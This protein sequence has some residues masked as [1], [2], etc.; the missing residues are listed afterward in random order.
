MSGEGFL[1]DTNVLSEFNH[2]QPP[3]PNVKQWVASTPTSSL[4][5][6]VIT[7]SEI[8][9]GI[10]LLADGKRRKQLEQWLE[11]DLHSWFDGGRILGIDEE[12][13]ILWARLTAQRQHKGRPLTDI[14]DGLI[15]ATA[16][17]HQLTIVTRDVKD[18]EGLGVPILNPWDE[19]E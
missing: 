10:E 2:K 6:S 7:L 1:L 13:G 19:K 14:L 18:F 4:Y 3:D 16:A 11:Q 12:T 8:R 15:A 9:F 17:K 5:V